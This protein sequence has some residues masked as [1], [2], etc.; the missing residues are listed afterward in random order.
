MKNLIY[1]FLFS[2]NLFSQSL[3]E[4]KKISNPVNDFANILNDYELNDLNNLS[5]VF[6]DSSSVQIG[7]AIYKNLGGEDIRSFAQRF[8]KVNPLGDEKKNNG[9]LILISIEDRRMSIE[10]GY[11]VEGVLPDAITSQIIRKI[12]APRFRES[13]YYEGI[14]NA[15]LEIISFTSGENKGGKKNKINYSN[16]IFFVLMFLVFPF[17]FSGRSTISGRGIRRNAMFFPMIGGFSNRSHG[18]GD[19]WSSGGGGF[20]GG[21]SSG[22]W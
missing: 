8:I 10:T 4:I 11:G 12:I 2:I 16:V 19:F 15:M 13:N 20:G 17:V 9:V 3:I 22:S 6:E 7:V 5:K 1:L 14:K 21:G 18:G